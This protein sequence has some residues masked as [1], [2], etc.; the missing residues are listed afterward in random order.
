MIYHYGKD[1]INDLPCIVFGDSE[2]ALSQRY[3]IKSIYEEL[4]SSGKN[5][6]A[7]N[8]NGQLFNIIPLH[9]NNI[10]IGF[11]NYLSTSSEKIDN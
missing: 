7:I 9:M 1:G 5:L 3:I 2:L 11:V 6:L 8:R 4:L 10:K